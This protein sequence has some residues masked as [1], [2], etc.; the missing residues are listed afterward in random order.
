MSEL[1]STRNGARTSALDLT[2][3]LVV[4]TGGSGALGVAIA[5]TLAHHGAT[6][7]ILDITEP[8]GARGVNE[9]QAPGRIEHLAVDVTDTGEVDS[10]LDSLASTHGKLPDHIGCLAGV[11]HTHPLVDYPIEQFD[12]LF[13][14]NVKGSFVPAR[15][16]SRR[17]IA[18]G[19]HGNIIFTS[20]WV[21]SVPWPNIG[22]YTASKAAVVQLARSFARELAPEKIRANAVAPGIVDAGMAKLQWETDDDYRRRASRAIPLGHL[23]PPQSVADAFLFLC[24]DLSSYMTGATLTVDG[25]AS[26]YPMD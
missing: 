7:A 3:E 19:S 1:S 12:S 20:S 9:D 15:A 8:A 5:S 10:A 17:W 6:V 26:L 24:S 13:E 11:V 18:A 14:I 21:H 23:Q 16:L 25:G 4:L 2:G 22:P